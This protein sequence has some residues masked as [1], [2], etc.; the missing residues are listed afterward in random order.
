MSYEIKNSKGEVLV[1]IPETMIET[2]STSLSLIGHLVPM[3]GVPIAENFV[4]LLEHFA[5]DAAPENPITGQIWYDTLEDTIKVYSEAG[6]WEGI[7]GIPSLTGDPSAGGIAGVYHYALA[8]DAG[9][10]LLIFAG[11]SIIA[12]VAD[13]DVDSAMLPSGVMVGADEYPISS[14]FPLGLR[15]GINLANSDTTNSAADI[16]IHGRVPLSDQAHFAGG[17]SETSQVSGWGYVDLGANKSIGLMISNGT[18]VAAISSNYVMH[19]DLPNSVTLRIRRSEDTGTAAAKEGNFR[20]NDQEIV[21]VTINNIKSLFPSKT[22]N[23]LVPDGNGGLTVSATYSNVGIF[24]G[25]TFANIG[26]SDLSTQGSVGQSMHQ[27]IASVTSSYNGAIASAISEVKTWVD[28]N[29]ATAMKI[30]SV[31]AAFTGATGQSSLSAAVS[32]IVANATDSSAATTAITN[33]KA[34]FSTALG[35][36]TFAQALSKMNAS[37]DTTSA[38]ASSI[39]SITSTFTNAFGGTT[40]A[41]A[42]QHLTTRVDA[43][44]NSVAGWGVT[45]NNNGYITG[46]EAL[47]GGA[48]NNYFKVTASRFI[49]GDNNIDYVPFEIRDGVV[50]MKDVVAEKITYGSLVPAFGAGNN[51]LATASG[52]QVFP[53]GFIIQ[54]GRVRQYINSEYTIG[55]TFPKTFPNACMSVT[56]MPYVTASNY[57]LDYWMQ[58]VGEPTRT[59]TAFQTQRSTG[60][61]GY[62][63]GFDWMA[64]GY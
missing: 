12:I 64:F 38:N 25:M 1:D 37:A 10:L 60:G 18:V 51:Q 45:L 9:S 35:T 3:Y 62:L 24:P 46:V 34:E 14:N 53:G 5:N 52:Y 63:N 61:T 21:A 2:D 56:A 7:S 44:G 8:D 29:S 15:A 20:Y 36:A 17:G 57:N 30:D 50:Y 11:G 6:E 23:S 22:Y 43:A 54:W 28:E 27:I 4:R 16:G 31:E 26:G 32:Y 47:N 33:L 40:L 13:R 59:G 55:V 49:I 39:N 41:Q 48:Q 58:N 42:V 19:A